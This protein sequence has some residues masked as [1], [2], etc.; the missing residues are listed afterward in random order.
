[1][2]E[3]RQ[4]NCRKI[5][6]ADVAVAILAHVTTSFWPCSGFESERDFGRF[7]EMVFK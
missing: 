4:R 1:M 7:G 3:L 6:V 5:Q 2:A